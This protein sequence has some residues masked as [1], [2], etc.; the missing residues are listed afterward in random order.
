MTTAL[1]PGSCVKEIRFPVWTRGN[2]GSG[3]HE[4]SARRSDFAYV[5]AAAQISLDAD[6]TCVDVALGL[7][8]V[9]DRPI[10]ISLDALIGARPADVDLSAIVAGALQKALASIELP[11]DVHAS[12]SYR[13]RLSITFA[14]RAISDAL[15]E[16]RQAA[17]VAQ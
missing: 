8:G 14:E 2:I 4:I 11:S 6:G 7:G 15:A 13:R 10:R 16:A 3:F 1:Q 9:G 17:G 12:P 5:A